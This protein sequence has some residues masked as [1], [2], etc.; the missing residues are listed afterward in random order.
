MKL[1][2]IFLILQ[3]YS[4]FSFPP[5]EDFY[6][7]L[8]NYDGQYVYAATTNCLYKS[9][10]YGNN[11]ST[12]ICNIENDYYIELLNTDSTGQ[13]VTLLVSNINYYEYIAVSSD[14]GETFSPTLNI[15]FKSYKMSFND[16]ISILYT[17]NE[18]LISNNSGYTWHSL[19]NSINLNIA[20][21][22]S[23]SGSFFYATMNNILYAVNITSNYNMILSYTT[24]T[25]YP[26]D[27]ISNSNGEYLYSNYYNPQDGELYFYSSSNYGKSFSYKSFSLNIE[28]QI[29]ACSYDGKYI[30]IPIY[31]SNQQGIYSA[32]ILS[33]TDYGESFI[34]GKNNFNDIMP[35]IFTMSGNG[36]YYYIVDNG[37]YTSTNFGET[38]FV[39]GSDCFE[40]SDCNYFSTCNQ[41]MNYDTE[42]GGIC[43][44]CSFPYATSAESPDVIENNI[45]ISYCT[46]IDLRADIYG[47]YVILSIIFLISVL[48][49]YLT[50]LH[51]KDI[52]FFI[53]L[54]LSDTLITIIYIL[55]ITFSNVYTFT[56]FLIFSC[57]TSLHL[58]HYMK[59]KALYPYFY[60]WHIKKENI[61]YVEKEYKDYTEK[62]DTPN[63]HTKLYYLSIYSTKLFYIFLFSFPQIMINSIIFI[64]VF[65][66]GFLLFETKVFFI[67]PIYNN[68]I[69]LWTGESTFFMTKEINVGRY[70]ES[71]IV[72]LLISA[73]PK[74][75]IQIVNAYQNKSITYITIIAVT[76]SCLQFIS[77][78][79]TF[80]YHFIFKKRKLSSIPVELSTF[81]PISPVNS[82]ATAT[83]ENTTTSIEKDKVAALE[84]ENKILLEK[85]ATL[86]KMVNN[87]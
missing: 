2:I 23:V 19:N 32:Y 80:T 28:T 57:I 49:I 86:E 10:D 54:P 85:I 29:M 3:I 58:I 5:V 53:A 43:Q 55:Y 11:Y 44:S 64:P 30:F 4:N 40:Q 71:I 42:Y 34:E 39:M 60:I 31:Y 76:I 20:Y 78:I 15:S 51:I 36:Q 77:T 21:A 56:F 65:F 41:I 87:V 22:I 7:L 47:I 27:L 9:I 13:Y 67:K 46:S 45:G 1:F 84:R 25:L 6:Y 63:L 68:F 59:K 75:I 26:L 37:I 69:Y 12:T 83:T 72:G 35:F 17:N 38:F 79:Y 33:S 82:M 62:S 73:I 14:Y 16:K 8:S 70:N 48:L 50:R 18:F 52:L 24:E 81:S 66:I 74:L 61:E